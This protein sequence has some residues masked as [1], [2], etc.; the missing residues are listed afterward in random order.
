MLKGTIKRARRKLA[1]AILNNNK[2][3]KKF[4]TDL[5]DVF[6]WR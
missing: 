2:A 1:K 5:L 4:Y 6:S 3:E